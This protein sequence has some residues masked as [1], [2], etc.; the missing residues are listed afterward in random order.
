MTN[1]ASGKV[2]LVG[3][4]PGDPELLTRKAASLLE[5]ADVVL[6]DDLVPQQILELAGSQTL[7]ASVGKRC[8]KRRVS[9]AGIHSLM[10]TCA[11]K[12]MS[13][14]RL[15]SGDPTLF[16]RAGEEIEALKSAG[17]PFEIVPGISAAFAAAA[18]AGIS[19]TDRRVASRV[20][21][22]TGHLAEDNNDRDYWKVLAGAKATVVIYMPGSDLSNIADRLRDGG[23]PGETPCL[24]VSRASL[25]DQREQRSTL[26]KLE[27]LG[28]PE[29]PSILIVGEVTRATAKEDALLPDV[30]KDIEFLIETAEAIMQKGDFVTWQ[31]LRPLISVGNSRSTALQYLPRLRWLCW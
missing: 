11:R 21:F 13:V 3:A 24:L 6:H 19:L 7:I 5:T 4:G 17:I 12:G 2:Y 15:K 8:G 30:E 25:A 14:I 29:A 16:G 27:N 31:Q 9:Q 23:W 26:D 20:T 1:A 10:I 22:A 28:A 18:A